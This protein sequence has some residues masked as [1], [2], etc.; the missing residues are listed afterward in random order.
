MKKIIVYL[1]EEWEWYYTATRM[2]NQKPNVFEF[3][4]IQVES[5]IRSL[6]C[7]IFEH[8]LVDEGFAT[9]DSGCIDIV[10]QRCGWS[11]GRKWLY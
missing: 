10:C 8:D 2:M 11:A 4:R 3:I 7:R 5:F 1:K 9:P 6:R